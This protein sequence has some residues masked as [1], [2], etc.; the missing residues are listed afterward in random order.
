M[1][2][3]AEILEPLAVLHGQKNSLGRIRPDTRAHS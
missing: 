3:A 1:F 2:D